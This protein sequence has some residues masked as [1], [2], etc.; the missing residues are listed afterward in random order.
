[1][2]LFG[3]KKKEQS[4]AELRSQVIE[5]QVELSRKKTEEASEAAAKRR[6]YAKIQEEKDE[7]SAELQVMAR[8]SLNLKVALAALRKSS[9]EEF[10]GL[11]PDCEHNFKRIIEHIESM[12]KKL[13]KK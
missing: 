2:T 3:K 12:Q 10:P 5:K 11:V 8:E 1:M 7:L 9:K 13:K 4:S 6:E